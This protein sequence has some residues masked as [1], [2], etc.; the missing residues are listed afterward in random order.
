MILLIPQLEDEKLRELE[1]R[2][3]KLSDLAMSIRIGET[4]KSG[5][6][7]VVREA[8]SNHPANAPVVMLKMG[9]F[10]DDFERIDWTLVA[11]ASRNSGPTLASDGIAADTRFRRRALMVRCWEAYARV[12]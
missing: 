10:T 4:P 3:V 11:R 7:P 6:R 9:H 12:R 2:N 1:Y 5:V 8:Y